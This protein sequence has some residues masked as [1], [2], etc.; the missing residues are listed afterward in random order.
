MRSSSVTFLS[1]VCPH[2][3]PGACTPAILLSKWSN[4][5]EYHS[6]GAESDKWGLKWVSW[7]L[8][9][10]MFSPL[11]CYKLTNTDC[12]RWLS[13]AL[14]TFCTPVSGVTMSTNYTNHQPYPGQP[15]Y[16]PGPGQQVHQ[17]R[18]PNYRGQAPAQNVPRPYFQHHAQPPQGL[19]KTHLPCFY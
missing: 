4:Q 11:L 12:P 8:Y 2:I 10:I 3:S 17:P 1:L 6:W 18:Y 13:P 5:Q 15:P 14:A 9:F 19:I 16:Q 7:I